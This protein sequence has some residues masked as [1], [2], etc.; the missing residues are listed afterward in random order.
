MRSAVGREATHLSCRRRRHLCGAVLAWFASARRGAARPS[1]LD[2]QDSRYGYVASGWRVSRVNAS[3][4]APAWTAVVRPPTTGHP[5]TADPDLD[6][7]LHSGY[8]VLTGNDQWHSYIAVV[9]SQG[10]VGAACT[11]PTSLTVDDHVEL[12]PHASVLVLQN[13]LDTTYQAMVN[14]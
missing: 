2:P 6:L 10:T 5:P 13:V 11:L 8:V 7:E 3:T 12:L 9:T 4:G 1:E 14:G